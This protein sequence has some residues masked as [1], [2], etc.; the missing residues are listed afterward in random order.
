MRV[1]EYNLFKTVSKTATENNLILADRKTSKDTYR[2]FDFSELD[3]VY[4]I[5]DAEKEYIK[6]SALSHVCGAFKEDYYGKEVDNFFFFDGIAKYYCHRIYN[7]S[8]K[9]L[10]RIFH[11]VALDHRKSERKSVYDNFQATRYTFTCGWQEPI[12]DYEI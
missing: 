3:S 6:K 9:L 1:K 7:T 12:T 5:S 4:G 8:G 11:L 10:Y 2:L